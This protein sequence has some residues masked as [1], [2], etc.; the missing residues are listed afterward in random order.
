MVKIPPSTA[1]VTTLAKQGLGAVSPRPS[2]PAT[3]TRH[4][5]QGTQFSFTR[6]RDASSST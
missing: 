1:A 6:E 5:G 2:T 4:P 3:A